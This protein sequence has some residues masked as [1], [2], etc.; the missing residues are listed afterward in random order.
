MCGGCVRGGCCYS[1]TYLFV[2]VI[3]NM[4]NQTLDTHI[5]LKSVFC[6]SSCT[7]GLYVP[8]VHKVHKGQ[9]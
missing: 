7:G 5:S 4:Q 1:H 6:G 9:R 3:G 2:H 8:S